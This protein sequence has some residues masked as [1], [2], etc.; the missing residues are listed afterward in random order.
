MPSLSNPVEIKRP[1]KWLSNVVFPAPEAP[2]ILKNFPG[3]AAPET[4]LRIVVFL[5]VF[6]P[7]PQ[8]PL[9]ETDYAVI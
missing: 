1:D 6:V 5:N 7:V 4:L 2:T 8:H 9:A 3:L